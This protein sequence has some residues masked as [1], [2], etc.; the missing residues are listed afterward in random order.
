MVGIKLREQQIALISHHCFI[1]STPAVPVVETDYEICFLYRFR[2]S[3]V[4]WTISDYR[5]LR[6]LQIDWLENLQRFD[7]LPMIE[8]FRDDYPKTIPDGRKFAFPSWDW[9]NFGDMI[10]PVFPGMKG[11][12]I[13]TGNF[14]NFDLQKNVSNC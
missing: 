5:D 12:L 13:P 7:V 4:D 6:S 2:I 10:D 1:V 11:R 14:F 8:R 3:F 9:E